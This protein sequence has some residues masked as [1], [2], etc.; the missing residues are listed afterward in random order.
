MLVFPRGKKEPWFKREMGKRGCEQTFARTLVASRSEAQPN[1]GLIG[2][3]GTIRHH[4]VK[5]PFTVA[6]KV[7]VALWMGDL[8]SPTQHTTKSTIDDAQHHGIDAYHDM[9]V[10]YS[11]S[12]LHTLYTQLKTAIHTTCAA[13][14]MNRNSTRRLRWP[15]DSVAADAL[16]LESGS[17][18][19]FSER[20]CCQLGSHTGTAALTRKKAFAHAT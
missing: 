17:S 7:S 2:G 5:S 9:Q 11:C 13:A 15:C 6:D 20:S 8:H 1:P 14:T 18:T 16:T 4:V 19:Y 12:P 10:Y 3:R